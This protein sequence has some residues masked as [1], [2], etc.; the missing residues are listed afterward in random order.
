MTEEM[1]Q[2]ARKKQLEQ[3]FYEYIDTLN[4]KSVQ[5]P[6]VEGVKYSCPCC[7]YKTLDERGGYDICPVCFWEDDG[8][9][10]AD[11]TPIVP[12]APII[13]VWRKH[14]RTINASGLAMNAFYSMCDPHCLKNCR[15]VGF[16][17]NVIDG[18]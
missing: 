17:W 4:N 16:P 15:I 1:E 3:L 10:D 11:A 2:E 8:Q 6:A 13:S 7:G 12:S 9:D 14:E 18:W 5:A